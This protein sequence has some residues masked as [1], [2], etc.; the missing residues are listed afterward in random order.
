MGFRGLL[1]AAP[2]CYICSQMS[3][4]QGEPGKIQRAVALIGGL[5]RAE[6]EQSRDEPPDIT[7]LLEWGCGWGGGQHLLHFDFIPK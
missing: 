2:A 1:A 3:L 6:S 7:T 5:M 4:S